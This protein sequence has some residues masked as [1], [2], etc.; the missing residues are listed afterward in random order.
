M[1]DQPEMYQ[2]FWWMQATAMSTFIW[3]LP[4]FLAARKTGLKFGQGLPQPTPIY[5]KM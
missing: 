4:A 5:L 3:M 2:G 1:E